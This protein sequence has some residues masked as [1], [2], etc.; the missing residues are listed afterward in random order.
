MKTKILNSFK[1]KLTILLILVVAMMTLILGV[2]QYYFMTKNYET[3][4]EQRRELIEENILKLMAATDYVYQMVE[5]PIERESVRILEDISKAYDENGMSAFNLNDYYDESNGF[6][7]YI[8]DEND[9]IIE[10][11]YE[12]DRGLDLSQYEGV[13]DFLNGI[14]ESGVF[15]TDRLSL[16]SIENHV[17]KYCYLPSSDGKYI[18]ETGK[19]IDRDQTIPDELSFGNFGEVISNNQDFVSS[20]QLF[21]IHGVTFNE[22]AD[23]TAF[24]NPEYEMYYLQTIEKMEPVSFEGVFEGQKSTIKYLPYIFKQAEDH[25]EQAVIEIVYSNEVL[26]KSKNEVLFFMVMSL[27]IGSGAV[28]LFAISRSSILISPLMKIHAG[29]E[30]VADGDYDTRI[31]VDTGDEF[32]SIGQHFNYMTN[33]VKTSMIRQKEKEKEIEELYLKTT[34][35]NE[36]L[37]EMMEANKKNY[38]ET[39]KALA[40]AEEEK[41][42]YTRGHSE[43]VMDISLQ[44][45]EAMNLSASDMDL[46]RFGS[47]LHDIGKIGVPEHILNKETPLTDEE[48][49]LIR[50]HPSMGERILRDLTFMK[51]SIRIVHEHHEWFSG[52]GYPQGLRGE[53]IDRLARIVCVADAFDAMT[54]IR[55]YRKITMS[56]ER[57]IKELIDYSGTQFDPEIVKVFI[58]ILEEKL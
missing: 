1:S 51:Y 40:N 39:I 12:Q 13:S 24:I 36:T 28:A 35:M 50:K 2:S 52:D 8:I 58:T 18:F 17:T 14:R 46:L 25:H 53:E 44:I 57:A 20:V 56:Y 38:F 27:L 34:S 21:N 49:D 41:D 16:S 32:A 30:Q 19:R 45:G 15:T 26:E 5:Y 47:I 42:A 10:A 7:L 4:D 23:E 43:R 33:Q 48:F 6:D 31:T 11:T 37:K 55:P 3:M 29:I 54:T 22:E 9:V